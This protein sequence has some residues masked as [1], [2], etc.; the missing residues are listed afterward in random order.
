MG[1]KLGFSLLFI[2]LFSAAEMFAAASGTTLSAAGDTLQKAAD[3][4]PIESAQNSTPNFSVED[5]TGQPGVP[6]PLHI[7]VSSSLFS[8]DADRDVS[9]ILS[10]IPDA[11]RL[12]AGTK[13]KRSWSV[14][15]EKLD[16]LILIP[17]S[18]CQGDFKILV[19]I[20]DGTDV[21]SEM[22]TI[23]VSIY[24]EPRESPALDRSSQVEARTTATPSGPPVSPAEEEI[25]LKKGSI[26]LNNGDV[27]AARLNFEALALRG[28]AKGAF[29]MA[30]SF[31]PAVL[32]SM[33][34]A[35]LR[36]DLAK[37]KE[38][39]SKA[40]QLGSQDAARRLSALNASQ[41]TIPQ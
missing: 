34:I 10:G 37:A 15:V 16:G 35:G 6:L 40:A 1:R 13:R 12:S 8:P 9:I 24:G 17:A 14:P 33:T 23:F 2:S 11:C 38:W 39:Y 19:M 26:L 20:Y 29:A 28:S 31:D 27:S 32:G 36:P 21:R 41:L 18:G 4:E 22:R 25:L 5:A 3:R 7:R 30:Q